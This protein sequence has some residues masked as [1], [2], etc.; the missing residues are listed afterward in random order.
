MVIGHT[1]VMRFGGGL[2]VLLLLLLLLLFVFFG[3]GGRLHVWGGV[4]G[5]SNPSFP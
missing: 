5:G 2:F 3:G 4:V 1:S